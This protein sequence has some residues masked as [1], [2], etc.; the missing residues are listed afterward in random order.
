LRRLEE[1]VE[2]DDRFVVDAKQQS[3]FLLS[4]QRHSQ[5]VQAVT[6]RPTQRHSERPAELNRAQRSAHFAPVLF[7]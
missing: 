2:A 6:H 5:F 4:P 7:A 3:G 1:G